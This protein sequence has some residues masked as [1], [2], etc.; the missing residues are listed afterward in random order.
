MAHLRGNEDTINFVSVRSVKKLARGIFVKHNHFN[1]A[2]LGLLA[3]KIG[4]QS[5]HNHNQYRNEQVP[6][7]LRS[8][9]LYAGTSTSF[10]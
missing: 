8:M 6:F 5:D 9:I 3:R 10:C 4:K 2:L 1:I 7:K